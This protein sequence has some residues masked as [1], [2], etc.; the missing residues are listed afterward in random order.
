MSETWLSKSFP[1]GSINIYGYDTIIRTVREND[2]RGGGTLL[3]VRNGLNAVGRPDL[4]GWS[5]S[6]W[7]EIKLPKQVLGCLYRPPCTNPADFA[8]ALESSLSKIDSHH[9]IVLVGDFNATSPHWC[10]TDS[11]SDAGKALALSFS[12]FGLHQHVQSLTHIRPDGKLGG[13]LDVVLTNEKFR[14]LQGIHR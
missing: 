13:L 2:S 5:E 4:I 9:K 1:T 12:T 3:M 6:T 8:D 14:K 10:S 7:I 11:F